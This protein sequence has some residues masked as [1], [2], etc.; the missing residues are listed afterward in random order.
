M[1]SEKEI[2]EMIAKL[3]AAESPAVSAAVMALMWV[4]GD[5]IGGMVQSNIHECVE[6]LKME[7]EAALDRG[8]GCLFLKRYWE[9]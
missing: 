9:L 2:D 6:H 3:S 7:I 1:R 4:R 8:G 5:D